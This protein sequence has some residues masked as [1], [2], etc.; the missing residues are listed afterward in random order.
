[1]L[2]QFRFTDY[3]FTSNWSDFWIWWDSPLVVFLKCL[4]IL[5]IH[6]YGQQGQPNFLTKFCENQNLP[7]SYISFWL[8]VFSLVLPAPRK[9][10]KF[11]F[12][13]SLLSPFCVHDV[14]WSH[15]VIH[16]MTVS[17]LFVLLSSCEMC[18]HYHVSSRFSF[19]LHLDRCLHFIR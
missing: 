10:P 1:M 4:T 15:T 9:M 8:Y 11:L 19:C 16:V 5:T 12:D 7:D 14:R 3:R 13:C 6:V 17:P 2:C 18:T